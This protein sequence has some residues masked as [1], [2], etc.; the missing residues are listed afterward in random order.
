MNTKY[1][2]HLIAAGALGPLLAAERSSGPVR[3]DSL[4]KRR[5][6]GAVKQRGREELCRQSRWRAA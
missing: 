6:I 2:N 1:R 4:W 5:R 3:I